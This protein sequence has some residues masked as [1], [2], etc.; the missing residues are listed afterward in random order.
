MKLRFLIAFLFLSTF[1]EIKAQKWHQY[2]DSLWIYFQKNDV[3]NTSKF[4][5]LANSELINS[6]IVEDS[7]YANYLLRKGLSESLFHNN[8][9]VDELL[10]S[11]SIYEKI[12]YQDPYKFFILNNFIGSYYYYKGIEFKVI[13]DQKKAYQYLKKS[14]EIANKYRLRNDFIIINQ[15]Y[16]LAFLESVVF[17]NQPAAKK[18]LIDFSNIQSYDESV[19]KLDLKYLNLLGFAG[20][21]D[22][23]E[24]AIF[25]YIKVVEK[26]SVNK[27]NDLFELYMQLLDV[28]HESS[29]FKKNCLEI[30]K[31]GEL[32]FGI[33]EQ[34][35]LPISFNLKLIFSDLIYAYILIDDSE[36]VSKY[37]SLEK[38]Y[39]PEDNIQDA[40]Y[41]LDET[42]SSGNYVLAKQKFE[43]LEQSLIS[44]NDFSKLIEL[45][46]K[47]INYVVLGVVFSKEEQQEQF[48]YILNNRSKFENS[49]HI[50]FDKLMFEY[51]FYILN[52]Y[53]KARQI[54]TK[55]LNHSDIN[56]RLYFLSL[57]GY[58][59]FLTGRVS[60]S[61]KS[62]ASAIE[63]IEKEYGE[64]DPRLLP[65]LT[66]AISADIEGNDPN[67]FKIIGKTLKLLSDNKLEKSKTSAETW[68]SLGKMAGV[69]YNFSDA[70]TYYQ[71]SK[72]ICKNY[73]TEDGYWFGYLASILGEFAI[74]L[75]LK[76][77][78][79]AKQQLDLFSSEIS[80]KPNVSNITLGEYNFAYASLFYY[81][82]EHKKALEYYEKAFQ[83]LGE[84]LSKIY[85]LDY[86]VC[87]YLVNRDYKS[88]FE[89]LN[90]LQEL[91]PLNE[92]I[93]NIKYILVY[94]SGDIKMAQNL[95]LSNIKSLIGRLN[96]GFHLM[97]DW[98]RETLYM[99]SSMRFDFLNGFLISNTPTFLNEY[100]DIR[101]YT[102]A[103]LLSNSFKPNLANSK[104]SDLLNNWKANKEKIDF[105]IEK[106][107]QLDSISIL[108]IKNREIEQILLTDKEKLSSP[109]LKSLKSSLLND[110]A[111]VEIIRIK[112]QSPKIDKIGS[113]LVNIF[114]DT[115]IYGAIIIKRNYSPKFVVIDDKSHL[116]SDFVPI[117][118]KNI[119]SKTLD[120][121][122][123]GNLF[124]IIEREL[125]GIKKVYFVPDGAYNLLN[126]ESIYNPI[127]KKYLIQYLNI[128]T[129]TG[130]RAVLESK[131][132]I[133]KEINS[134]AVFG[135][136][137]FLF[138]GKKQSIHLDLLGS[139]SF[140]N[141]RGVQLNYLKG[142]EK[143]I[144]EIGEILK[145]Q[146]KVFEI[147]MGANATEDNFKKVNS[148]DIIHIATHGY[149]YDTKDTLK[150]NNSVKNLL[151]PRNK[152]I[153]GTNSGLFLAGAQNTL[154]GQKISETNN[155]ILTSSEVLGL[156]LSNT[157][158]V[159]LSACET[160]LGENVIGEG[161][162]G[163]QRSFLIAGAKSLIMSLWRV[164]DNTTRL[165]MT[166]F[167][168]NMFVHKM[169][170]LFALHQA[171][172]KL[173]RSYPYPYDWGGF[174]LL[175]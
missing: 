117:Y 163:L 172:L 47:S 37:K 29:D 44:Q 32:A 114:S 23:K 74:Y 46:R 165:L 102:K 162:Y 64:N 82:G 56:E 97:S 52:N 169:S 18:I 110:E 95:L 144:I 136:P 131:S 31:Y 166:S 99:K 118:K 30:I 63:I 77:F 48:N 6:S 173:M 41:K 122:S 57:N 139:E 43:L 121:V 94:K 113:D 133:N 128:E 149:F 145:K 159:V 13:E 138:N 119:L 2:S 71:R 35:K 135:S 127:F 151:A 25:D 111:Y 65:Y 39:F 103:L 62:W 98:Q 75:E 96:Q 90:K 21:K 155:G 91:T 28:K 15:L 53:E 60:E 101:F 51:N 116:E 1:C 14:N 115:I 83:F 148:H 26:T 17:K 134:V 152:P 55:Y 146:N 154:N 20:E 157:D 38:R 175:Q 22:L 19:K 129:V 80:N 143:E 170:K 161:V 12:R 34:N 167:Y 87:D 59:G 89:K 88:T 78:D 81:Q 100:I 24:Q 73:I 84:E 108:E 168:E 104:Q 16:S 164:N 130:C 68:R 142:A 171:K 140:K 45:Y 79:K 125:V 137:V 150:L 58:L 85:K 76:N 42:F 107:I 147:H 61:R 4:I 36:N 92:S 66:G 156:N 124:E 10:K 105:L 86:I 3:K 7:T 70:I 174:I 67:S 153:S 120:K 112:K 126:I 50:L 123:F 132:K 33:W 27:S 9:N 109:T 72:E 49:N 93:N 54:V 160:G 158:L 106:N 11:L 5:E 69:N 40:F 141:L 8:Y